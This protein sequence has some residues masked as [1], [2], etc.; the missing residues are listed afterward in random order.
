MKSLF[1]KY[2]F[3][4]LGAFVGA[5]GGLAY[6]Y[7]IGCSSGSCS[8]TSSPVNSSIYGFLM[9]ALLFSTFKKEKNKT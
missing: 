2:R 5:V 7:F 4:L 1:N 3:E 6:W 8:I 9:G